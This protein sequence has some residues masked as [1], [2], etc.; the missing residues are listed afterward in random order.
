MYAYLEKRKKAENKDIQKKK[1]V[2]IFVIC[3]HL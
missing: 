3:L 1:S 2:Y